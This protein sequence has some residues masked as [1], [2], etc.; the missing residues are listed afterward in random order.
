MGK[1]MQHLVD[2]LF[3]QGNIT[4]RRDAY[5]DHLNLELSLTRGVLCIT[6]PSIPRVFSR[7]T[8]F[9]ELKMR[10]PKLK[11]NAVPPSL[12]RAMAGT[13]RESNIGTK[14]I[15]AVGTVI[16]KLTGPLLLLMI[17]RSRLDT[18]LV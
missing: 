18:P 14:I 2:I 11:R 5:L 3:V 15:R 10:L 4:L 17:Q 8:W 6:A 7:T 13:V 9:V 1:A 12:E 16:R